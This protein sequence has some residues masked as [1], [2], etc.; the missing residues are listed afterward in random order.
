M[1]I[2]IVADPH[3]ND[4]TYFEIKDK[5][6]THLP[7]RTIDAMKAFEF[8][9]DKAIS[10]KVE[11]FVNLGDT[12]DSPNPHND[13]SAFFN[14]QMKKLVNANIQVFVIIGNHDA[15]KKHHALKPIRELNVINVIDTPLI[16]SDK[17]KEHVLF[18]FPHSMDIEHGVISQKQA[19]FDFAK[20]INE[21]NYSGKKIF[22]GHIGLNGAS[23]NQYV[24]KSI[25]N[26]LDY[27]SVRRMKKKNFYDSDSDKVS[28]GD[29]DLLSVDYIFL[30]DYHR[31]QKLPTKNSESMYV[32]SIERTDFNEIGQKKGFVIY[33]SE[34]VDKKDVV[35]FHEYRECR[36]FVELIGSFNDIKEAAKK[37]NVADNKHAVVKLTFHGTNLEYIEF[38][39]KYDKIKDWII[40]NIEPVH[41]IFDRKI[42]SEIKRITLDETSENSG[43]LKDD[44]DMVINVVF[45]LIDEVEKVDAEKAILKDLAASVYKEVIGVK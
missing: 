14:A 11:A 23:V 30:G 41:F 37:I 40:K 20:A 21:G 39:K 8:I 4:N 42:I 24:D 7:F 9:V 38:S 17:I 10:E 13:V 18:F 3:L 36:K 35:V 15:A 45:G 2:A 19:F 5:V 25:V 6:H 1:K 44:G 33:D 27:S 34:A 43:D 31:H 29:L 12:F 16:I 22:F 26:M 28:V 32:G